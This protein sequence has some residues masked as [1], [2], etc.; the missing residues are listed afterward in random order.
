M[1]FT[2]SDIKTIVPRRRSA[3]EMALGSIGPYPVIGRDPRPCSCT[4]VVETGEVRGVRT[5]WRH[6]DEAD[7]RTP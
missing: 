4:V 7:W 5:C 2:I 3:L 1:P 6:R